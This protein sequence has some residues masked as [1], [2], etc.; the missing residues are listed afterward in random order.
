MAEF[1]DSSNGITDERHHPTSQRSPGPRMMGD[2][3]AQRG[4]IGRDEAGGRG[5]VCVPEQ[6]RGRGDRHAALC[7]RHG[8]AVAEQGGRGP[9]AAQR[10]QAEAAGVRRDDAP[11]G[12]GRQ[13]PSARGNEQHRPLAGPRFHT[14]GDPVGDVARSA[15]VVGT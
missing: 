11:H 4:Q 1:S 8:Q 3:R 10:D 14:S 6:L 9:S 2:G 15:G 7:Q 13:T 12:V 5:H